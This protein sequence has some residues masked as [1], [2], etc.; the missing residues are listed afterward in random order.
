MIL[1]LSIL[2]QFSKL[3][4]LYHF[5]KAIQVFEQVHKPNQVT[6]LITLSKLLYIPN[7]LVTIFTNQ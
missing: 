3:I 1:I 6:I 4:Y 7:S 5:L 2:N